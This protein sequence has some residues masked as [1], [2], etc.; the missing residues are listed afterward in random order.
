MKHGNTPNVT[1][2]EGHSV[3]HRSVRSSVTQESSYDGSLTVWFSTHGMCFGLPVRIIV[4]HPGSAHGKLMKPPSICSRALAPGNVVTVCFWPV[5]VGF[6]HT[7]AF[8]SPVVNSD[9]CC[10][11]S[12][13]LYSHALRPWNL[14]VICAKISRFYIC[15]FAV[16]NAS[17]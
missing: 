2:C 16:T 12:H 17:M 8:R 9:T 4:K 10:F 13:S 3:S 11:N 5:T 15:R 7:G 14:N 1:V 6:E